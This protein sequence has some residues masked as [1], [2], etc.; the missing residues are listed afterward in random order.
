MGIDKELIDQLLAN[1]D[2]PEDLIGEHG[3]LKELTRALV[4][5][6]KHAESS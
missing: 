4:E 6:A 3:L 1:Y 5:R 2:G